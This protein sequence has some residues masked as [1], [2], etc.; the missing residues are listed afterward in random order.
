M[1][2]ED[3]RLLARI[4]VKNKLA[5]EEQIQECLDEADGLHKSG[6][7]SRLLD[8]LVHRGVLKKTQVKAVLSAYHQTQRLYQLNAVVTGYQFLREIGHGTAGTVYL[9]RQLSIGRLVA[10]KVL[11]EE[12]ASNPSF[13]RNFH[14]EAKSA[15]RLNHPNVIQAIDVGEVEGFHF[16][17]M[18][19]VDGESLQSV[20][21]RDRRLDEARVLDVGLQMASALQHAYQHGLIHRDVKPGNILLNAQGHAKLCDLGLARPTISEHTTTASGVSAGTPAYMSPEQ[22]MG[23]RDLDFRTDLFSLG[24]SLYHLVTGAIPFKADNLPDLLK[25]IV[26]SEPAPPYQRCPAISQGTN[27]IVCHLMQKDRE[28]R[29]ESPDVVRKAIESHLPRIPPAPPILVRT[30]EEA[31]F[32]PPTGHRDSSPFTVPVLVATSGETGETQEYPLPWTHVIV[33]RHSSADI[34]LR[35]QWISRQQFRIFRQSG[36]FRIEAVAQSSRMELNGKRVK[37]AV[38]K[39]G[40]EITIFATKMRFELRP[41]RRE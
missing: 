7:P 9:A 3:Q 28:M 16:F 38:L 40:D 37:E 27:D 41:T 25:Q 20:M 29:P 13:I 1:P 35:D 31:R 36:D 19:Y 23:R 4:V 26:H 34:R 8:V 17:V 21:K 24:A 39:S 2:I 32:A 11:D 10:I 33:G 5:S 15:A 18:E 30:P 14:R 22:A 12:L 6:R